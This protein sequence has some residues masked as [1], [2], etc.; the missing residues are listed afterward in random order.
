MGKRGVGEE[1]LEAAPQLLPD[2]VEAA[3]LLRPFHAAAAV[4]DDDNLLGAQQALRDAQRERRL[5]RDDAAGVAD[6]VPVA[7]LESCWL[8]GVETGV[9]AGVSGEL[10]PRAGT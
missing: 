8:V 5:V 7:A 10:L 9:H 4:H 1:Q 3:G 2:I 6:D